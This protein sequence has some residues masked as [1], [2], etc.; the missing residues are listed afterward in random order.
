MRLEQVVPGS[1][2]KVISGARPFI[3]GFHGGGAQLSQLHVNRPHRNA[4]H[5]STTVLLLTL[6]PPPVMDKGRL[7][8]VPNV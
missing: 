6:M 1:R 4:I 8:F 2:L 3:P 7:A 5:S